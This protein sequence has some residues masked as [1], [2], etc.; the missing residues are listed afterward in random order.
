MFHYLRQRYPDARVHV[1]LF[2]KNREILD[3]MASVPPENVIPLD[4]RNL[5]SLASDSLRAL[6]HLRRIGIGAVIDCELFARIGALFS[7]LSG[8]PIRAGFHPYTQEGLFRGTFINRP[9]LYN[10]YHH[11]SEQF[12]TLAAAL[13]APGTPPAKRPVCKTPQ[14][15]EPI[16]LPS[17]SVRSMMD[18]FRRDHPRLLGR[19]LV[20]VY[21]SGGILPIR[22]WPIKHYIRLIAGLL[23]KGCGIGIVGM[24]QDGPLARSITAACGHFRCCDLTGYTRNIRELMILLDHADLLVTNDGGPGQFAALTAVPSIVLFGPETPDLY[25]PLGSRTHTLHAGLSCSPCLTAY[26]HRNSPCDGDNQCLQQIRPEAVLRLSL[27]LLDRRDRP[28]S[29]REPDDQ[30]IRPA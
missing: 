4:D 26:N 16:R 2:Q 8:A 22:A 28:L 13:D 9:V 30:R 1:L 24:P 27:D 21:P 12:I 25:A 6:R 10:P 18:R 20:L 29:P 17:D 19:P 23:E 11:L 15:L 3:I 7:R 14:P 5:A